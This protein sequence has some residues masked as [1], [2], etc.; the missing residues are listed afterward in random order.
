MLQVS[1][2]DV[3][4]DPDVHLGSLVKAPHHSVGFDL[5]PAPRVNG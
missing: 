2:T 1:G 3:R 5:V 4:P